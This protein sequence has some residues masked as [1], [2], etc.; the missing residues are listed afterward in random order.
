MEHTSIPP[1]NLAI[2][3]AGTAL[4]STSSAQ[5]AQP[6]ALSAGNAVTTATPSAQ[7]AQPFAFTAIAAVPTATI[8]A[9]SA[10][11]S[12]LAAGNAAPPAAPS[13]Q[14]AQLSASTL[15]SLP[16]SVVVTIPRALLLFHALVNTEAS[17]LSRVGFKQ[18][19]TLKYPVSKIE[20]PNVQGLPDPLRPRY[21]TNQYPK[22]NPANFVHKQ[23]P[24]TKLLLQT[25]M[26]GWSAF[27]KT[28]K[29]Y[30][31]HMH[32]R[33]EHLLTPQSAP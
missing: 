17:E 2:Q 5:S 15:D 21:A 29:H 9:Q 25:N 18:V 8:P 7:S 33:K 1:S 20:F 11:L 26:G 4:N 28:V 6:S 19:R 31:A 13:S 32:G 10:Q 22:G 16:P 12:A 27:S 3:A 14:S 30:V 23:A 24:G